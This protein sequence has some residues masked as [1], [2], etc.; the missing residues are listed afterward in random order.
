MRLLVFLISFLTISIT[1]AQTLDAIRAP[2]A[3][4]SLLLDITIVNNSKLV[5]VGERGHIVLSTKTMVGLLVMMRQY[6]QPMTVV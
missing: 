1:S 3:S 4:K 2:L 5:A 6:Y